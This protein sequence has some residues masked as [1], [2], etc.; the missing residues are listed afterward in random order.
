LVNQYV[1]QKC[2]PVAVPRVPD[3]GDWSDRG[4]G[5]DRGPDN[6][7]DDGDARR[8]ERATDRWDNGFRG[9]NGFIDGIKA[10]GG[11]VVDQQMPVAPSPTPAAPATHNCRKKAAC[12]N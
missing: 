11:S 3:R 10:E 2:W 4:W 7:D 5:G 8:D 1:G 12:Q 6:G 9:G